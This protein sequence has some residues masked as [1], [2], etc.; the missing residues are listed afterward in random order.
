MPVSGEGKVLTSNSFSVIT[1]HLQSPIKKG[2]LKKIN[3]A[4]CAPRCRECQIT[5][6][7]KGCFGLEII[8]SDDKEQRGRVA[9]TG[10]HFK[11]PSDVGIILRDQIKSK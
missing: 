11:E 7:I 3:R 10:M 5:K 2:F 4:D 6:C 9:R 8:M 1:K